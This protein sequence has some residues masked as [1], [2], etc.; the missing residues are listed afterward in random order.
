[1][2][3]CG[4]PTSMRSIACTATYCRTSWP[5]RLPRSGAPRVRNQPCRTQEGGP[6][7]HPCRHGEA[8]ECPIDDAALP[9][10][11][12][13]LADDRG[14]RHE[15]EHHG[16]RRAAGGN[17]ARRQVLE[18][19]LARGHR[20]GGQGRDRD[21]D[22]VD[23]RAPGPRI[24]QRGDEEEHADGGDADPLKN[25]ERTWIEPQMELRVE[26][27]GEKSR[28]DQEA[29]EIERAAAQRTWRSSHGGQRGSAHGATV[30]RGSPGGVARSRSSR[31]TSSRDV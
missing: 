10:A 20:Y 26:G 4:S 29:G 14:H 6:D 8:E 15:F 22:A 23:T 9:A 30:W 17:G 18:I 27:I 11:G 16:E 21:Q 24:V 1:M 3:A 31:S 5:E 28:A 13:D 12:K 2:S 19:E 25:A 7:Q